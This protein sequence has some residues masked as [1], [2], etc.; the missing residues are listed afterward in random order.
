MN[1]LLVYALLLKAT[2]T[3]FAG[4]GSLPQIQRDFVE[5][6]QVLSADQLSQA[7]LIGRSTPGPMGAYTVAV[8]YLAAGWPGAIAGWLALITPALI[9]IPLLLM[10]QR[11]MHLPHMRAAVDAIVL[12]SGVLLVGTGIR[13][14]ID[15]IGQLT[16]AFTQG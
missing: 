10:V 15:A 6:H 9:A 11:W 7:V 13:L 4:L 3:S 16:R 14:S 2:V 1:V 5:T 12:A 8:G